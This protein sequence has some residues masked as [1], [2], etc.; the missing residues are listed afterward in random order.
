MKRTIKFRGKNL[1][2]NWHYGFYIFVGNK[3]M[4][5][6]ETENGDVYQVEVLPETVGQYV[7][8]KDRDGT[9]MYEG[10]TLDNGFV[11]SY[12]DDSDGA[13]LGLE[14][15]FYEQRADFE[16]YGLLDVGGDYKVLED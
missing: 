7:G 2:G 6:A 9:E 12:V 16:S 8:I 15:G 5:L 4:I 10:M 3:H 1:S 13:N 14:V 11:I